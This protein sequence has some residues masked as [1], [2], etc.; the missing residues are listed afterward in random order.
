MTTK[1][2]LVVLINIKNRREVLF[3]AV[4]RLTYTVGQSAKSLWYKRTLWQL[5]TGRP[6]VVISMFSHWPPETRYHVVG[7]FTPVFP[8]RG[9]YHFSPTS[10]YYLLIGF[11]V[12]ELTHGQDTD[13]TSE[14]NVIFCVR[15]RSSEW[16]RSTLLLI[17]CI[18]FLCFIF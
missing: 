17:F 1:S 15:R 10:T 3:V 8:Y 2:V 16:V 11:P 6:L 13:Y 9:K 4:A 14:F 7:D 18:K 12:A 5:A